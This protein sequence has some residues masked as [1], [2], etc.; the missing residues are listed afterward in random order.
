MD[1]VNSRLGEEAQS[2][3]VLGQKWESWLANGRFWGGLWALS[4]GQ[5]RPRSSVEACENWQKGAQKTKDAG[6]HTLGIGW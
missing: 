1:N 5:K 4:C 6:V 2:G 3:R